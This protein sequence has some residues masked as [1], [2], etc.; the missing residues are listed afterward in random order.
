NYFNSGII[1][2]SQK[3]NGELR[4]EKAIFEIQHDF[5]NLKWQNDS[6]YF[7]DSVFHSGKQSAFLNDK[8]EY[9][10]TLESPV[11]D[12]GLQ[13]GDTIKISLWIFPLQA[14]LSAKLVLS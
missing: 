2:Y 13:K 8:F 1:L 3:Q 6:L 12:I 7:N 14:Q 5:E 9:G 4:M 10:P 11:K